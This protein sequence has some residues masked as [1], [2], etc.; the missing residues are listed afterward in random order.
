MQTPDYARAVVRAA[1]P[2]WVPDVVERA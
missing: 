1:V 2:K